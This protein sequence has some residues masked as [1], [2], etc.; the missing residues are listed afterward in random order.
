MT[1]LTPSLY[2]APEKTAF[3]GDAPPRRMAPIKMTF[4]PVD[5][6]EKKPARKTLRSQSRAPSPLPSPPNQ[7][8]EQSDMRRGSGKKV[9]K[10]VTSARKPPPTRTTPKKQ[11]P[12]L[13]V[14]KTPQTKGFSPSAGSRAN[15]LL[16]HSLHAPDISPGYNT[17]V[18]LQR[19]R[20][21][22]T[23]LHTS[24]SHFQPSMCGPI[25]HR[26]F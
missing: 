16:D 23:L 13:T 14:I 5:E 15:Q 8:Q 20:L 17:T 4:R 12:Q 11:Y 24:C 18:R 25:S 3:R 19:R 26:P 6:S 7:R 2:Q 9:T 22:R 1:T 10:R 21:P